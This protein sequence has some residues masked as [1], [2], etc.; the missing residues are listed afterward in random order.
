MSQGREAIAMR[1]KLLWSCGNV[2]FFFL[3]QCYIVN[4]SCYGKAASGKALEVL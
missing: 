3:L 4:D 2:G 1:G